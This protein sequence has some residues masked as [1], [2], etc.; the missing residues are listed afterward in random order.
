MCLL[1]DF[2]CHIGRSIDI[3]DRRLVVSGTVLRFCATPYLRPQDSKRKNGRGRACERRRCPMHAVQKSSSLAHTTA[4]IICGD[5][6]GRTAEDS[7]RP[8]VYECVGGN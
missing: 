8:D 4:E 5:F 2:S 6:L 7:V 3:Y 1:R